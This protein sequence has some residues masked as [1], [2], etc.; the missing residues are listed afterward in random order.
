M[1]PHC[2]ELTGMDKEYKL[3]TLYEE[4]WPQE[5]LLMLLGHVVQIRDGKDEQ[6]SDSRQS[7]PAI[8]SGAILLETENW[9]E[10]AQ[11]KCRCIAPKKQHAKKNEEEAVEYAKLLAKRMKEAKEKC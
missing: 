2:P 8:K 10:K 6:G 11:Y 9:K 3:R 1:A 4:L 7:V 5:W